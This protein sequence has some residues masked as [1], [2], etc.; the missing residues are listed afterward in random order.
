MTTLIQH[1]PF[2]R[3]SSAV[4]TP[5]PAGTPVFTEGSGCGKIGFVQSG[6]IR[7]FK[8]SETGREITLYRLEAGES[9]IL[10]MSCALSNPIH[11][12]SAVVEEDAEVLILTTS[13]FQHLIEKSHEARNYVFGQFASRLTDVMIVVEEV[14]FKR[15]DERLA[16]LLAEFA[17]TQAT[18]TKTHEELAVEL[19]T[20]REVVSRTLKEFERQDLVRLGRGTITVPDKKA[21]LHSVRR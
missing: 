14:V 12:A 11:Q 19:G 2:L 9:C 18:I 10:S 1:L 13:D 5:L 3:H 6:V 16:S 8:L 21:L 20:A 17:S 15:M 4:L 7:V